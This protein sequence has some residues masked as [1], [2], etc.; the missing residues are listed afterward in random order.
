MG[1]HVPDLLYGGKA[2]ANYLGM[3]ERQARYLLE[4]KTIPSF[5]IDGT[6]CASRAVI[7]QWL[8]K[9]Q[10]RAIAAAGQ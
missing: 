5:K 10:D 7:D 3:R 8:K 6:V 2:I 9:Q 4:K 1:E